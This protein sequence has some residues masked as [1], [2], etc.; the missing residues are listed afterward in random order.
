MESVKGVH[1]VNE[2]PK[3][4]STLSSLR[5]DLIL[6]GQRVILEAWDCFSEIGWMML[7]VQIG[8]LALYVTDAVDYRDGILPSAMHFVGAGIFFRQVRGWRSWIVL[9]MVVI[10]AANWILVAVRIW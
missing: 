7:V 9:G 10:V 8:V 4:I 3:T 5:G 1:A 6:W 2:P